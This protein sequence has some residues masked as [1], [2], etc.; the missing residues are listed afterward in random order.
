MEDCGAVPIDAVEHQAVQSNAIEDVI[1]W[2]F[3]AF[4]ITAF[5]RFNQFFGFVYYCGVDEDHALLFW[6]R[7]EEVAQHP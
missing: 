4:G 3:R 2:N 6:R 7:I 5:A 1:E